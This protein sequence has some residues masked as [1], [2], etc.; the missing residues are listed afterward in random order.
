MYLVVAFSSL[1]FNDTNYRYCPSREECTREEKICEFLH[2]F[3]VI[4]TLIS[5]Y[6]TSNLYFKQVWM[7]KCLLN[8]NI[9]IEDE[10]IRDMATRIKRSLTNVEM[11][12]VS[13]LHLELRLILA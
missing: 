1:G 7:I 9:S 12:I 10:V 2:L 8:Q 4:S 11:V 3:Y 5:C 6:P 13:Y